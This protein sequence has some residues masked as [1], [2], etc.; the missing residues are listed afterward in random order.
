M[1]TVW[2]ARSI[3][4]IN[5]DQSMSPLDEGF[6]S[7][8]MLQTSLPQEH[9]SKT[10]APNATSIP[11]GRLP[12]ARLALLQSFAA[13]AVKQRSEN[14]VDTPAQEPTHQ[15][16]LEPDEDSTDV[17]AEPPQDDEV[18]EVH[19]VGLND[20]D[21]ATLYDQEVRTHHTSTMSSCYAWFVCLI[22]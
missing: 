4:H 19:T 11:G 18:Q 7:Q 12:K 14:K 21:F 10:R 16:T 6:V 20:E 13:H 5:F 22:V 9:P 2:I 15:P 1:V 17:G 8:R 3:A